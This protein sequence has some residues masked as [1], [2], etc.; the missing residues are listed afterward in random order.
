[1]KKIIT[2]SLLLCIIFCLSACENH[3]QQNPPMESEGLPSSGQTSADVLPS[4]VSAT[5]FQKAFHMSQED[6][7]N[8]GCA[9]EQG[10]YF[11]GN[12]YVYYV[13]KETLRSTILCGKPE[14]QHQD[15]SCNAYIGNVWHIAYYD[16]KLY[17]ADAQEQG[18]FGG[19]DWNLYSMNTDGTQKQK[20]QALRSP[21]EGF[22]ATPTQFAI[23]NGYIF[24]KSNRENILCAPLG[25]SPEAADIAKTNNLDPGEEI[26]LAS[27][28]QWYLWADG[29][30]FYCFGNPK[31]DRFRNQLYAYQP[32]S[33]QL[34]KVWEV[35]DSADTGTWDTSD[36]SVNGWYINNGILYYFLSGNGLYQY[37]IAGK[38]TMQIA[39]ITDLEQTGTAEFDN[40]FAYINNE[41]T[42]I[43]FVYALDGTYLGK[44]D[45]TETVSHGVGQPAGSGVARIIGSDDNYVFLCAGNVSGMSQDGIGLGY[46]Y[47]YLV[48]SEVK[49]GTGGLHKLE[50]Q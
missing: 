21:N 46:Y 41:E 25:T 50:L 23:H 13:E 26:A 17:Y 29:E 15:Q 48:K 1:M 20:V 44:Y 4:A 42:N 10:Y 30:T 2:L 28:E 6:E 39:A 33:K 3:G 27:L 16:G 8:R 35:P 36:I 45:Y 19:K 49:A 31:A 12:G 24:Y 38:T 22:W 9:S 18:G 7:Y 47:Y 11:V 37:E 32:R 14:C 5:D 40:D 34:S 43:L